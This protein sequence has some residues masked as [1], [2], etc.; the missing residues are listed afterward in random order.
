MLH[1]KDYRGDLDRKFFKAMNIK[2]AQ[3]QPW[4]FGLFHPD[5]KK[6]KFVWYP[7]KGTLMFEHEEQTIYKV[8]QFLNSEDVYNE[9]M[10]K[11][12]NQQN[13]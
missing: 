3:Y 2:V 6:A 4:Q 11:I 7:R 13:G 12:N 8:G 9:I 1:C 5:L 10:T